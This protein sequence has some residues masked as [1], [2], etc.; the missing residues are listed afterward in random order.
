MGSM[1]RKKPQTLSQD[2]VIVPKNKQNYM[3]VRHLVL[4]G[5]DRDIGFALGDYARNKLGVMELKAYRDPIYGEAR[6]LFLQWN[7]PALLER[8]RGVADAYGLKAGETRFDTTSLPYGIG[9][10]ACSAISFPPDVTANGHALV[11]RN[12][13]Y[14]TVSALE[15][16]TGKSAPDESK[17][18]SQ[19]FIAEL[20]PEAGFASMQTAGFDLLNFPLDGINEKGLFATTLVDQQGP[21]EEVPFTGG[22]DAGLSGMQVIALLMNQCEGIKSAKK[23]LL[24]RRIF[25]PLEAIHWLIVD[26]SGMSAIFEIDAKTGQYVF[27]DSEPGKPQVIT[28]H[29]V[30]MYPT[31]DAFPSVD[32]KASYN[33]FNRYR[34][35]NNVLNLHQGKFSVDDCFDIMAEVYGH[36]D[37][38]E[39]AGAKSPYPIRTLWTF[40]TDLTDKSITIKYY[41]R[42]GSTGKDDND[43]RLIFT[44]PISMQLY[45]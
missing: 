11:A 40:V 38:S 34:T 13:E 29:A 4:Q 28:N 32:P 3:E 37:D 7:F 39:E 31:V 18:N 44:D 43:I 23:A 33:T 35:L 9:S 20:Y 12:Y 42:D 1:P 25:M 16:F 41:L 19:S 30:H 36:S 21:G 8:S 27:V 26:S 10:F 15:L 5:S 17:L 24:Q 45:A 14:Y 2:R 22:Q 6:Q